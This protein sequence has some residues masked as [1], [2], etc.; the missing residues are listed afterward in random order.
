MLWGEGLPE[1]N[2]D[3][4]QK[5]VGFLPDVSLLSVTARKA[6]ERIEKAKHRQGS[7]RPLQRVPRAGRRHEPAEVEVI[8][9]QVNVEKREAPAFEVKVV[10][11]RGAVVSV[12]RV[13]ETLGWG[14]ELLSLD[15][16]KG[17]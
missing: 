3:S 16:A 1:K 14:Q 8:A 7:P 13:V 15:T 9:Q 6:R 11:R 17:C 5:P 10:K 12:R 2:L 4:F